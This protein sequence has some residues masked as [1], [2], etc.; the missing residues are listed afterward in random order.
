MPA[1]QT[2]SD[3]LITVRD[4]LRY[5]VSRFNAEQLIYGHGTANALDEAAYLILHTLHLPIDQLDPW[6][7]ARLL[8]GERQAVREI[9]EA[10]IK[11]RKPAP[12]LTHEA[13][14]GGH[15]FYVDERVIVPRSY[16][17]EILTDQLAA[18]AG[19]WH[20]GHNPGPVGAIL[21]LCTGS[22]C[23]AILAALAFP[24]AVVEA[25]DISG[26][27][28]AVA[29]RNVADYRLE[30]RIALSQSDLFDA[31]AG[32]RYDLILANPPY[33]AAAA[34]AAFPP[35]YSAEP[36]IAHAGGLDGLDLVRRI[37]AEARGHLSATGTLLVEIGAG[38][39]RLEAQFQNLPFLWLDTAES[40]AQVFSLPASA[41]P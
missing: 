16:I 9:I 11:T 18:A 40:Q 2:T 19:E 15:S 37:L 7:E 14:I 1:R 22:G 6:L 38:R 29:Q 12:Y 24:Q 13:W 34:L 35:E 33:V 5:A 23:L 8:S 4:W 28:L 30:E 17:G 20:L 36:R 27:A 25:S 39:E 41:L 3:E 32:Q 31:H 21:D 10:R 26:D